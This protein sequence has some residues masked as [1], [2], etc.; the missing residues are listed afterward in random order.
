MDITTTPGGLAEHSIGTYRLA[1]THGAG[2]PA[3]SVII[4]A[5]LHDI[6]K[7]D[8]FW[9]KGRSIHQ[10]TPKCEMDSKHSVRSIQILR[11]CGLKLSEAERRA[12]RWH[13]KGPKYHSRDKENELD[14][15]KAV[16]DRLWHIVFDSDKKD[17][18]VHP[19]QKY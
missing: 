17:A 19:G 16:K 13:M 5:L 12:I 9:F 8:R 7:S 18:A 4:G 1:K 6:C 3:D 2:L 10:H 15:S 11:S 14:H